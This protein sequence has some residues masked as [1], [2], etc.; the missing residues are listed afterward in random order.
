MVGTPSTHEKKI[1]S[2]CVVVEKLEGERPFGR[3]WR[4]WRDLRMGQ[5]TGVLISP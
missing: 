5:T 3:L 2:Y 4:R 1:S